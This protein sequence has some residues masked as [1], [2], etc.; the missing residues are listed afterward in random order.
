MV[1]SSGLH[2][3][4][5]NSETGFSG[6][7]AQM[8]LLM[9][10][11]RSL[12]HRN[13]L[14]AR[15]SSAA[16][17]RAEAQGYP[18]ACSSMKNTLDLPGAWSIRCHLQDLAADVVVLHTGRASWLGGLASWLTGAT[19]ITV[20]RMDRKVKAGLRNALIHRCWTRRTVGVSQAV[21]DCLLAG[22][23]PQE[24]LLLIHDAVDPAS[25]RSTQPASRVREALG[26]AEGRDVLLV[27]ASLDRRKG[28]DVLLEALAQ[29]CPKLDPPGPMLWIAGDG[30]EAEALREQTERL[31]L[32]EHVTFLGRRTDAPDLLAACDVFV[33]PSRREGLGVAAL[34]AMAVGKPV[35]ASNV[36]GLGQAVAAG[37]TGLLVE[38]EDPIALAEALGKLIADTELRK[39]LA[40]AGPEHIAQNFLGSLQVQRYL[41][42]FQELITEP[43]A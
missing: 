33:L 11:L 21:I 14:I 28:I 30:P 7:E 40:A 8:F 26:V 39:R 17:Q 15:R 24:K 12:G 29:L 32:T 10:G 31:H 16:A 13:S 25:L 23:V 19:A 1:P 34:E 18:V 9:E 35:I 37:K 2:I 27:L 3:V 38:P 43:R 41:Q 5:V 6:G 36:G 4:H 22:G 20:R 42:L